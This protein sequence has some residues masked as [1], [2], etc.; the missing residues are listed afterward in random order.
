MHKIAYSSEEKELDQLFVQLK[1]A[2]DPEH[3]RM[4]QSAIQEIWNKS[5]HTE[6]DSL[7]ELGASAMYRN[8]P[9]RAIF[10]FSSVIELMPEYSEG[11]NKRATM[12]FLKED[13]EAALADIKETL[14]REERHFG[15]LSGKASILVMQGKKKEALE[16][17][18]KI[19]EIVPFQPEIEERIV[20]L[21]GELGYRKI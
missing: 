18:Q 9:E 8:S 13:H 4:T 6:I 12:F 7:M 16:V 1:V 11:W 10:Y 21:K 3:I 17:Y 2:Q 20:A 5:G 19:Q 15:A 14:Q